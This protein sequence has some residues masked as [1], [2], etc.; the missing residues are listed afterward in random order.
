MKKFIVTW[1]GTAQT[2]SEDQLET[3]TAL[4]TSSGLS[5]TVEEIESAVKAKSAAKSETK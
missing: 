4:L 3:F 5:H 1:P 2:V